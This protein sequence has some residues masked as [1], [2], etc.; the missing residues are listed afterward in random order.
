MPG[1][2]S[3]AGSIRA[4]FD[5]A[6]TG[7]NRGQPEDRRVPRPARATPWASGALGSD[8]TAGAL[9]V[10]AGPDGWG[11]TCG[12]GCAYVA[13]YPQGPRGRVRCSPWATETSPR[14]EASGRRESRE[15][16]DAEP[17]SQPRPVLPARCRHGACPVLGVPVPGHRIADGLQRNWAITLLDLLL[18]AF[19]RHGHGAALA[20]VVAGEERLDQIAAGGRERRAGIAFSTAVLALHRRGLGTVPRLG[21]GGG[22][23]RHGGGFRGRGTRRFRGGACTR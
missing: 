2:P 8:S 11:D 21:R 18:L 3:G 6:S 5:D 19:L 1:V 14:I 13:R 22:F 15:V 16:G 23:F 4:G 9:G 7:G 17:V 12:A 20:V 10:A